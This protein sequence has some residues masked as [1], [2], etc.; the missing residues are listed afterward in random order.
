[1]RDFKNIEDNY[2]KYDLKYLTISSV[3]A[4][5]II[6]IIFNLKI[7]FYLRWFI[8]PTIV[9]LITYILKLIHLLS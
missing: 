9:V 8:I 2:K 7:D 6:T 1:M 5:L 3:I 4:T